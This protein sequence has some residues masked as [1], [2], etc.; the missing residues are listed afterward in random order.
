[1]YFHREYTQE[2]NSWVVE[3][4][5]LVDIANFPCSLMDLVS[6]LHTICCAPL[7]SLDVY[8]ILFVFL[9]MHLWYMEV[10]RLGVES[11]L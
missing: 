10:P 8:F 1:M 4:H 11:E 7:P 2:W 9:G 6:H 3:V 5:T